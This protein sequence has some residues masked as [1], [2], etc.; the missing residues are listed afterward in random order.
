M[1]TARKYTT[2]ALLALLSPIVALGDIGRTVNLTADS[3]LD[4]ETG[5]TTGSSGDIFWNGSNIAFQGHAKGAVIPGI[6]GTS[7][8]LL[9]PVTLQTFASSFSATPISSGSLGVNAIF[10]VLTNAGNYSKVLVTAISAGSITLQFTTFQTTTTVIAPTVTAVLNNY[11]NVPPGFPNYGIAPGTLFLIKGSGL[12]PDMVP[13]LQSSAAPGIPTSLNGA[14]VAVTVNGTTVNPG[15]Y[16]AIAGQIAAVL[17]S[18]TPAG[19]G[20]VTV[21]YNGNTSA[22][23]PIVVVPSALGFATF[24]GTGSGQVVATDAVTGTL[25]TDSNSASP[26]QTVT[27]WGS[28]LG[29]DTADSDTVFTAAP[30]SVN[31][32]LSVYFGGVQGT[33]LYQGS[34][35]FPGVVQINVTIPATVAAGC[36]V[37][38]IAVSGTV[39][40]N[41]TVMPINQGGGACSDPEFGPTASVRASLSRQG[42][43]KTGNV[44]VGQTVVS[45]GVNNSAAAFFQS[46]SGAGFAATS[47]S[48]SIGGCLLSPAVGTGTQGGV[49]GLDAGLI[50]ITGP[51]GT[52]ALAEFGTGTY[53]APLAVGAIGAT[54]G[55][56]TFT[57]NG[58]QG[59]GPFTAMVTMPS[60]TLSW[61]NSANASVID[62]TKGLAVTWTGGAAGSYVTIAG[63]SS[64]TA[65]G[66]PVSAS[67]TCTAPVGAGQF[68]VPS[69]ILLGLPA[70]AGSTGVQNSTGF[71]SFSAPGIDAGFAIGS[72]GFSVNSTY[73]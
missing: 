7:F 56:F 69:Y 55:T 11:S 59:V 58:G 54:G 35:G 6:T 22:A 60:P 47:G 34:S 64:S 2:V 10:G 65:G 1:S 31:V 72:I 15:L 63:T 29:A 53:V 71:L 67:F 3:A 40:S 19:T 62:R 26:G 25:F 37:S 46:T 20:T 21:T 14:S 73:N 27:L 49:T 57:G 45:N 44:V 18:G 16:Y 17:P 51:N 41:S 66:Q 8:S 30:H 32:P 38:V 24:S 39:V 61:S 23:V 9:N 28:G 5:A 42:T 13:V 36:N 68:T 48:V 70:G 4:L 50:N 33:I 43:V 52:A 12:A